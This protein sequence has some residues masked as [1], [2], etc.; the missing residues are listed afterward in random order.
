LEDADRLAYHGRFTDALVKVGKVVAD[1]PNYADAI[2]FRAGLLMEAGRYGEAEADLSR[3][4][5]VHPEF[6]D[7]AIMRAEIEIRQ[8]KAQLALAQVDTAMTLPGSD[9]WARTRHYNS[10]SKVSSF[11]AYRSI[12]QQR[13][14]NDAAA[15]GDLKMAVDREYLRPWYVPNRHC[16]VAAVAG[17]LNMAE[18]TCQ[19]V[20]DRSTHDIAQYDSLGFV[21]LKMKAWSKALADYNKALS[22][23]PDM[24]LS[25]YGRGVAKH[26]LG[27]KAGG[28]AD[29]AAATHDEP[30]IANIMARLGAPAA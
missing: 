28:D 25:V 16:Y 29:I 10:Y 23:R 7:I 17:L 22:F 15:V 11:F 21:H 1:S 12:A 24:T 5:M 6:V 3:V 4:A 26:A 30:D 14:G 27:D 19:E 18:L 2:Y 20:A 8:R 13:A 9:V